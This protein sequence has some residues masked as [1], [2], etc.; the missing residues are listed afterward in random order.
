MD[1]LTPL[2]AAHAVV[3]GVH[4]GVGA[5][6]VPA[7]AR[8]AR[9][10][11]GPGTGTP[12]SS[13]STTTTTWSTRAPTPTARRSG[14]TSCVPGPR[15][16][17]LAARRSTRASWDD[18]DPIWERI[19][20]RWREADPGNDFAVHGTAIVGVLRPLP[21]RAVR[22]ARRARNTRRRRS[23]TTASSYI[24]CS[25]RAAGSSSSEPER[26]AGHKDVVKRVLAGRG[27]GQPGRAGA[28]TTSA[29]TTRPGARTRIGGDYPVARAGGRADDPALRI[30]RGRHARP[31][32][33]RAATTTRS[34]ELARKLQAAAARAR[35]A[36]RRA[37]ACCHDGAPA[38]PDADRRATP[39]MRAA[40]SRRRASEAGG[41]ELRSASPASTQLWAGRDARA[42]SS[43]DARCCWS[44]ST[45]SVRAYE[46]RCAHQ[47]VALSE[48][49]LDGAA[50]LTCAAHAVA[51]R[52]AHRRGRQPA[53]RRA[54][55][56]SP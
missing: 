40:R 32:G 43:T 14:S 10:A 51:V 31:A 23:S 56:A 5:R 30:P 22:T 49:E 25:S 8:G 2:A 53:R 12:S 19:T 47:G 26:Y 21:A 1:Y 35:R 13:R 16:A 41:D 11:S 52:R 48:G 46:D 33:A 50:S 17:R 9:P 3:Q 4:G 15:R 27:A 6:S 24:F 29:S 54:C 37:C 34:A 44:T 45:A 18:F 38:R 55:A 36:A 42:S 7:L 20:E 39:G 28:A